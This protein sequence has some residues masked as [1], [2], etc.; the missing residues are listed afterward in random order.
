MFVKKR[1]AEES[2]VANNT[3]KT[4]TMV[5]FEATEGVAIRDEPSEQQFLPRLLAV[6]TQ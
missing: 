5:M 1:W 4:I 6:A 2:L 3:K